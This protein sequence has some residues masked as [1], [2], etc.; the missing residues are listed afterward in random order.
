MRFFRLAGLLLILGLLPQ[1]VLAVQ[2]MRVPF[3]FQWGESS[4]R[5]EQSLSGTKAKV[6]E[7][8]SIA[9]RTALVV[10]GIPQ[11][12]LLRVLFYFKDDALNEIELHYGDRSWETQKYEYF[13]EDTRKNIEGKYGLG[14]QI[15]RTRNREGD[16]LQT[17]IGYEWLQGAMSLRLFLFTAT[18]D[19]QALRVL[20]LHYKEF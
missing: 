2:Q 10:E 14:R 1:E 4:R 7:H 3:N 9:G 12:Q 19:D 20:S 15:S 6:V 8:K 17:L 11:K 16:V 18:K 13:F 5:V